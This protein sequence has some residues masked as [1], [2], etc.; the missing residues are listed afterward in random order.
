MIDSY[1]YRNITVSGKIAVGTSTLSKK[2]NEVLGWEYINTGDLQRQYDREHGIAEN[3]RGAVT[4]PDSHE[5]EMEA[6]AKRI[7]TEKNHIIY[8]AWLSGFVARNISGVLK[9]LVV[10]SNEAI[11]IDRVVNRDKVSVDEAKQFIK[12]REEENINKWKKLYGDHDFWNPKFYDLVIDT[13]SSGPLETVGKV[14][15][16]LG[17]KGKLNHAV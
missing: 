4:R 12:T 13:Y 8:E 17:Y 15:D 1:I 3:E 14:L 7:L 16:S 10:C 11:R 6:M 5:Q 2:L 9:V